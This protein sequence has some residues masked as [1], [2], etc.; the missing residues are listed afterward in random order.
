MALA[1]ILADFK[2]SVTQCDSL[3]ANAHKANA[4]GT[5]LLPIMDQRQITVAAF[6][7]L[8]IAWESFLEAALAD[9]MTGGVPASGNA[10]VK[11]VAP[12]DTSAANQ[13]VIGVMRHFDYA[14]HLNVRKIVSMYFQAGYP[15]EPHLGAIYSDLDDL[16]TLRNA[17]AHI[18]TTTQRALE[19]LAARVF[20]Q[21]RP[22]IVLYEFITAIDPRSGAAKEPVFITY[23]NKL[24]VTAE[25]I[26]AG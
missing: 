4:A 18:S 9:L 3:I 19:G 17:S 26:A 15:F 24:I 1:Q 16:R 5:S 11:F 10:P 12:S 23:R 14:N 6:L 20:G 2:S 22:G 21:P 13:M 8:F 25:L 7:N